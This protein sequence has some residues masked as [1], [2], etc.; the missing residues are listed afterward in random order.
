MTDSDTE[1]DAAHRDPAG[2]S[3]DGNRQSTAREDSG[4]D[5]GGKRKAPEPSGDRTQDDEVEADEAK[6][7][8]A[9]QDDKAKQEEK[10]D[11]EA[12][13]KRRPLVISI[14]VVI[15]LLLIAGGLYYWLTTR[16]LE[17]T[18]DAYTDGRAITIASQVS[19]VVLSL[20]V[21]DNQFVKKE[22]LLIHIDPRQYVNDR[23]QAEGVLA[24]AKAQYEGQRLAA[25]VA[26][27]NFPA[28]LEQAQAQLTNARANLVRAEADY[29]RQRS[30]PKPATSQQEV[31]AATAALKQAQAQ[32]ALADAQVTQNSP[33]PQR[34]GETDA[35]VGQLKGQVEQAQ[36][37]LDQANLNL[38]WTLVKA[39]KDGWITKRNVEAGNYITAG[40][41]IFSIVA[42]EVWITANF[43]ESQL[44][45]MR[46][47]QP[48]RIRIDA[49]PSLDLRGHVDSI[50]LG[51]GSKFTAFPPENAT[52][53]FVKV[54]QRVPV[55][56]VID[57]GLNPD[58]PLPLGISAE[59][60]VTVR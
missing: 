22:Q 18:D 60:T 17:S 2:R 20:A 24:T 52:G 28:Q 9:I 6:A 46:P 42:P 34:I 10:A 44:A 37:R 16:N 30:L 54:V 53:N 49:Y 13:Q 11:E 43:K 4:A 21:N 25:E 45:D 8:K 7:D 3:S 38:S 19:G 31:D 23:D 56:I 51:S 12:R 26:R 57:S 36:A 41:Q 59:P 29:E 14:G 39:P 50:Q 33:V 40:Q 48:V 15:V 55:K 5:G 1:P 35:Q 47:G 27:K 58:I 32:V